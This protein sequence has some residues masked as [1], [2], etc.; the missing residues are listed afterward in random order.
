MEVIMDSQTENLSGEWGWILATG[1]AYVLL[2]AV[3]LAMP[4]ASTL[5]LTI[6]LAAVLLVGGCLHLLQ[7]IQ[8][9]R[10]DG[11]S[12]RFV[13]SALAII[14]GGLILRYPEGGMLALALALSFYFFIGAAAQWILFTALRSEPGAGWGLLSAVTSLLLGVFVLATFPISAVW[15]P[16]TLLGID[17]IFAGSA[18]IGL[19]W[20]NKDR[21]VL[22]QSAAH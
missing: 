10:R 7:S 4:V 15:I 22:R 3:A 18:M 6:T 1:I 13:Q 14:T 5:G 2:G 19:A 16:G 21:S 17:L 20:S 12:V 11:A 9:S 8:V